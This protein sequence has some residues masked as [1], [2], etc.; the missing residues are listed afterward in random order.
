M[1]AFCSIYQFHVMRRPAKRRRTRA[2]KRQIPPG[3]YR[4]RRRR[5]YRRPR[6]SLK[7]LPTRNMKRFRYVTDISIDPPL[8]ACQSH[9]FRA[10]NMTSPDYGSHPIGGGL[11]VPAVGAHQPYGFDQFVP[12]QYLYYTV[13]GSKISCRFSLGQPGDGVTNNLLIGVL[14]KDD[15]AVMV[16]PQLLRERGMTR[17]KTLTNNQNKSV[18][19]KFSPRKFFNVTNMKD[20]EQLKGGAEGGPVDQAYFHVWA[21]SC[22]PN[23]N[24]S[25][26]LVNIVI[27][28]IAVL[29]EPQAFAQS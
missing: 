19:K 14:L 20:N 7:V 12:A 25:N 11:P 6:L 13:I 18:V 2:R 8:G 16:S 29:H 22:A 26:V 9:I 28:Y 3:L 21:T 17:W 24:P 15:A 4:R 10:N 5:R 1:C 27:E 23:V